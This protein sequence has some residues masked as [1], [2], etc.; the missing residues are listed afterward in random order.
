M[1]KAVFLIPVL[2]EFAHKGDALAANDWKV[3]STLADNLDLDAHVVFA[4]QAGEYAGNVKA[5][6]MKAM[7]AERD[8]VL[9]EIREHDP[10]FIVCFGPVAVQCAVDKGNQPLTNFLRKEFEFVGMPGKPTYATQSLEMVR[11][12]PGAEKWLTLD[13][14]AA[15]AGFT[16]TRWGEY[17]VLKPGDPA[18]DVRPLELA[19]LRPGSL[20]GFD[21]ETYPSLDPWHPEARI[22]MAV[23]SFEPGKAY[24]VQL[25]TFS[26]MPHWL[27][28]LLRDERYVKC[29]S[30][31]KYD[32]RWCERF[33]YKV[34][35]VW[36]TSSAEHILDETD[37]FKDLKSL[38]FR[39]LPRLADYSAGH[40]ALVAARGSWAAV[41]DEEQ[42]DYAGADGEASI[43]AA[44]AQQEQLVT[45]PSCLRRAH[46]LIRELYPVLAKME[47]RGVRVCAET[48]SFLDKE[49]SH[50]LDAV[51]DRICEHLGPVNPNSP[52]QLVD[53]LTE[54]VPGID[55]RKPQIL[56]QLAY[57]YYRLPGDTEES[58]STE[59]A[60]LEREASKHPVIEDILLWRRLQKLHGTYVVGLRDKHMTLH[61]DGKHYVH[62]SYR[63]DV[64]ETYRLSSQ[65][66]NMQNIPKKPEPD[67]KHPIPEH[68]NIKNQFVSRFKGGSFFEADLSQAEIRVAAVLSRDQRM[69]E[70]IHKGTD[71]HRELAA[72]M[73]GKRPDQVTDLERHNCKRLTF[74]VLYGGGANTLSAQ[75]GIAKEAA[76]ALI[77]QYFATFD[78]LHEYIERVK[79]LVK[80]DLYSE[81]VFGFRRRLRAPANWNTWDGWRVE[82]MA[83]N[84]QVQNTAACIT[85]V[86]MIDLERAMRKAGLRSLLMTQVHDSV[87]VDVYP[88]EEQ[89]VAELATHALTW[90][91]IADYDAVLSVPLTADVA[92]GPSWGKTKPL[93]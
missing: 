64:V 11:A 18:W 43:A 55:L 67:E 36:D 2:G 84:F 53:A 54:Q 5:V 70:A 9:Q 52:T 1:K 76:G 50:E 78:K 75:L 15:L 3:L 29:G 32:V 92:I 77:D 45:G 79:R 49:F 30:N 13:L 90:P 7:R 71:L 37:P 25:P 73:L 89:Q 33:G 85:Y 28:D 80:R 63:T 91:R 69:L 58:F 46:R 41:D 60:V 16:K 39:Y 26:A 22:R 21:L 6:T 10:D 31:I 86:A 56:R 47:T 35:N 20:V 66:P 8:R 83:W 12:N 51:R 72:K 65:G 62:T 61:T 40:R 68:L 82:R 17:V 23:V 44:S 59:R 34:L 74:L 19:A 87:G 81:S 93:A 27:D 24:V 57:K 42:Y 48:N 4:L 14:R 88:G 38:T